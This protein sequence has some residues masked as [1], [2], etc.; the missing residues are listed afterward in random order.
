M[1]SVTTS[2]KTEGKPGYSGGGRGVWVGW[3]W[4]CGGMSAT[5]CQA[6]AMR[7]CQRKELSGSRSEKGEGTK[8]K[9]SRKGRACMQA[10]GIGAVKGRSFQ[11]DVGTDWRSDG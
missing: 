5:G 7:P 10:V 4:G 3:M 11:K 8:N 6:V 2:R 9:P 1:R